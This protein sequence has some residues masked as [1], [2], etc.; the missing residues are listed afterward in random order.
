MEYG[1]VW[2]QNAERIRELEVRATEGGRKLGIGMGC[3]W[4]PLLEICH[5][6]CPPMCLI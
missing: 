3:V 5:L 2:K 4:M 1:F 6:F